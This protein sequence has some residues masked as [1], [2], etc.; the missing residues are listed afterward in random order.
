[1]RL[2]SEQRAKSVFGAVDHDP[3]IVAS[4]AETT[5]DVV[6]RLLFEKNR[7]EYGSVSIGKSIEDFSHGSSSFLGYGLFFDANHLVRHFKMLGF[8]RYVLVTSAIVLEKNVVTDGIDI[9][10]EAGGF[11]DATVGSNGAKHPCKRLLAQV[12][13]RIG[14]QKACAK[15]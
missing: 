2:R 11:A 5:A 8:Q 4:D 12:I 7:S 10:A 13:H 15:F 14:S 6:F 9:G 3:Q 1:M